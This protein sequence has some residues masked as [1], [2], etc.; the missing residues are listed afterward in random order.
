MKIESKIKKFQQGG[1]APAPQ[2]PAAGGAPAEG[3]P[4]EGGAPEQGGGGAMEQILQV[5]MQAVQ[6]Q[7]C[8]AAMA[9]CQALVEAA[10]GGGGP[11]QAPQEE[12][13]FARNGAKLVRV[14]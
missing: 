4:V 11:E 5:A 9:V 7:N 14:R 6:T 8:E 2:D 13:T 10:Q 1:P 12:P 3:A